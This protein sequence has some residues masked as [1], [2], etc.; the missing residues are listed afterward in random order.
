MF[1]LFQ[2]FDPQLVTGMFES[3]RLMN[4]ACTPGCASKIIHT[5]EYKHLRRLESCSFIEVEPG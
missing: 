2:N 1:P 4:I 5:N 3:S